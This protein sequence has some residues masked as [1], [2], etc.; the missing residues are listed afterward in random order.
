MIAFRLENGALV[1]CP[2]FGLRMRVYRTPMSAP[3]PIPTLS[4]RERRRLA[5]R[6]TRGRRGARRIAAERPYADLAPYADR[7]E[8]FDGH[9]SFGSDVLLYLPEGVEPTRDHGRMVEAAL[10]RA[11]PP[12]AGQ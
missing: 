11:Y 4:P 7:I 1:P 9:L 12:V 2:D 6:G 5:R 8:V 10:R 3:F